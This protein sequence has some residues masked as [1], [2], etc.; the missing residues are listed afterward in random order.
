MFQFWLHFLYQFPKLQSRNRFQRTLVCGKKGKPQ[1]SEL[2]VIVFS[3]FFLFT[4]L[5]P[6]TPHS[7]ISCGETTAPMRP[8]KSMHAWT[9][10]MLRSFNYIRLIFLRY[11]KSWNILKNKFSYETEICRIFLFERSSCENSLQFGTGL[12]QLFLLYGWNFNDNVQIYLWISGAVN[13]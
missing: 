11:R 1:N 7:P 12:L 8:C 9:S 4:S 2:L 3:I 5:L 6:H 10:I 13:G